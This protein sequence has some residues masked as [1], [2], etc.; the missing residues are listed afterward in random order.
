MSS[1]TSISGI[2]TPLMVPL[3]PNGD[4]NEEELRRYI[5]WLIDKGVHGLYP[6]GSTGE[7]TRFS[8]EE[9]RRIIKI[10]CDQTA[11][12]VP[13][14]AGAA[15]A[16]IRE[17]LD[18][19][20][21]YHDFGA[22]AVAIVSPFYYKLSPESVFAY[23]REIAINSPIDVTLYNIPLFASPIDN[24]TVCRLAEFD[25]IIG[26]KDSSGDLA[27]MTRMIRSIR[28]HRPDFLFMTGWDAVLVPML[29]AGCQG[30]THATSGIVPEI[31]RAIYDLTK[32]S[33]FDKALSLQKQL[34]ELFDTTFCAADFPEGF[35]SAI[36][37]RGFDFGK[38]RQPLTEQ[39]A[40][41]LTVATEKIRLLIQ[42]MITNPILN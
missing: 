23:F 26:I 30:G 13:V 12:R 40:Q 25:R 7:F 19:C 39:Q 27:S 22:R 5:D 10:V 38:G 1:A 35:R 14:L 42:Q 17:T 9:R 8:A 21:A 4:I 37:Q 11:N 41:I 24:E 28:P 6:N 36:N 34:L 15:E 31:T 32:R 2:L 33:D 16:N 20:S 3:S 18:A 29:M